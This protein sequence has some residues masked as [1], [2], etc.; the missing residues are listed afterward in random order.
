MP[1]KVVMAGYESLHLAVLELSNIP[2]DLY[3]QMSKTH[4]TLKAEFPSL[5]EKQLIK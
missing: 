3:E 1:F 2:H 5:A 4:I